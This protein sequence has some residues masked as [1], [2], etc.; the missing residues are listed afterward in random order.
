MLTGRHRNLLRRDKRYL[1][2][3]DGLPTG[4]EHERY[5]HLAAVG[6]PSLSYKINHTPA[7][8][9]YCVF[10]LPD[11]YSDS[12]SDNMQKGS[13]GTD[14]DGHSDAK[15]QWNLVKF[16]LIVANISVKLGT[17]P[18]SIR[19]GIGIGSVETVLHIIILPI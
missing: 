5:R 13:T 6:T 18:I 4:S 3:E 2:H 14:S 16:H 11:S 17:V 12:H 19:I 10:P 1:P 15:S 8:I 7:N 9:S